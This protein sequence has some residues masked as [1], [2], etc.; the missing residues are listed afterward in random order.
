MSDPFKEIQAKI[1]KQ[2]EKIVDLRKSNK[3]WHSKYVNTEEKL[4]S[5]KINNSEFEQLQI[6][7]G[8]LLVEIN[9]LKRNNKASEKLKQIEE[10]INS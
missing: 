4:R 9:K 3:K 7:N 5:A 6:K 10:I 8:K 2:E 1:D